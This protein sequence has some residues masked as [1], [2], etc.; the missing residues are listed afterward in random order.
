MTL[1]IQTPPP[2]GHADRQQRVGDAVATL[3]P[4]FAARMNACAFATE[5]REQR[6]PRPRYVAF[7][8]SMYPC[9]VGFNGA[10]IRSIAKVDH[11]RQSPLVRMLAEQLEEEQAH[12][13]MWREKLDA[14]GIDHGAIY[15]AL[16][17]YLGRFTRPELEFMTDGVLDALAADPHDVAPGCFPDAIF[18]EPI[19]AV[20]QYLSTSATDPSVSFWAH[21]ASQSAIE[22]VIYDVVSTS[23]L[24]GLLGNPELDLGAASTQWWR[25]H[26]RMDVSPTA[27]QIDEE[28]HLELSRIALNRSK[29]AN[30]IHSAVTSRAEHTLRLFAATLVCQ[31]VASTRFPLDRF[32]MR[33]RR[34]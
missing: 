26:G 15:D 12:N 14:Y 25:E 7:V 10:L 21:F 13:Q 29:E 17:D 31:D 22:M 19:L 28:R 30:G 8:S 4:R 34:A 20:H 5:L 16:G 11:V 3:A 23:I 1:A 24:P 2:S 27:E 9:V 6:M 32:L 33:P 18:P